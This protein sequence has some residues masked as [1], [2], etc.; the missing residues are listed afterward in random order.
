MWGVTIGGERRVARAGRDVRPTSA[1]GSVGLVLDSQGMYA[2]ALD[3]RSAAA[4]L[5]L[6]A[7]DAVV[8]R[9]R[10]RTTTRGQAPS[11]IPVELRRDR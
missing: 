5:R 9:R 8:D 11:T 3:Q 1:P 2:L 6:D 7:G 4:E 10:S